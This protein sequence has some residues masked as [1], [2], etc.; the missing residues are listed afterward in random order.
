[1]S[2]PMLQSKRLAITGLPGCGKTRVINSMPSDIVSAWEIVELNAFDPPLQQH[3]AEQG[4]VWCVVDVRSILVEG[5]DDWLA[6]HLKNLVSQ[7][8]GIVF[9]FFERAPLDEQAWWSKWVACHAKCDEQGKR[10][11][12]VRWLGQHFPA[13]FSK[14]WAGFTPIKAL[15]NVHQ[16][17]HNLPALQTFHFTVGRLSLEH[18]LFGIDSSKQNLSMKILRVQGVANTLEYANLVAIEGSALRWDTFAAEPSAMAGGLQIQ[19][20]GLE[21]KWLDEIV[22]A[23]F[24]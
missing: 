6:S 9:S 11:P 21:Q 23:S 18:L 15:N 3:I 22:C 24:V 8:D 10:T 17:G 19:G 4:L 7:A 12:I 20:I 2:N 13:H 1:M 14:K 5:R 16:E